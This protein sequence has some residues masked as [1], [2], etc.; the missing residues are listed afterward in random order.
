M[1]PLYK[2]TAILFGVGVTLHN[3]EEGAYLPAWLTFECDTVLR[4]KPE[5]LL[6]RDVIGQR[7]DLGSDC[8]RLSF[9]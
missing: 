6:V 4:A 9:A 7:C 2:L 1:H 5:N 8:W 3:L